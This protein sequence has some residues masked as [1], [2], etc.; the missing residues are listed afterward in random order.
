LLIYLRKKKFVHLRRAGLEAGI[1]GPTKR[2]IPEI[3]AHSS[4]GRGL[5]RAP[6]ASGGGGPVTWTQQKDT[7]ACGV[8]RRQKP[9]ELGLGQGGPLGRQVARRV[10]R[11]EPGASGR[12]SVE[13]KDETRGLDRPVQACDRGRFTRSTQARLSEARTDSDWAH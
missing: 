10:A 7:R 11:R 4:G 6:P 8:G 3:L 2:R 12:R 1:K 9:G 5:R 13:R